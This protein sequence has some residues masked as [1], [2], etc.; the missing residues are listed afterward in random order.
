MFGT[1]TFRADFIFYR[2]LHMT[3]I[4]WRSTLS[5]K[6]VETGSLSLKDQSLSGIALVEIKITN[7]TIMQHIHMHKGVLCVGVVRQRQI[8]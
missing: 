6:T 7:C 5:E 8:T 4:M 3:F 2:F 1:M